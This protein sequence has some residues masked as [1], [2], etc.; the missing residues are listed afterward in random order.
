[1]LHRTTAPEWTIELH[2]QCIWSRYVKEPDPPRFYLRAP[3]N[4]CSSREK[5][6]KYLL[7]KG[8]VWRPTRQ[9][10]AASGIAQYV[11]RRGPLP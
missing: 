3:Q 8:R 1:M 11:N 10:H 4:P 6:V 7:T 9:G 2:P 5:Y